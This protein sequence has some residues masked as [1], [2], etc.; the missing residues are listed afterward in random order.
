MY[1]ISFVSSYEGGK[2]VSSILERGNVAMSGKQIIENLFVAG[3]ELK[4]S[5]VFPSKVAFHHALMSF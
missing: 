1:L 4:H 5:C 3:P 2:V